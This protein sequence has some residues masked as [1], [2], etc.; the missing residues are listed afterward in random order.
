MKNN[1]DRYGNP[2]TEWKLRGVRS[3]GCFRFLTLNNGEHFYKQDQELPFGFRG[4]E[5][6][7]PAGT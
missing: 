4:Q 3:P 1:V 7:S 6:S 5:L 2:F